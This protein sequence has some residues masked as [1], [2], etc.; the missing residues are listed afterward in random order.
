MLKKQKFQDLFSKN[1][2]KNKNSKIL[3]WQESDTLNIPPG[4]K[5]LWRGTV[6]TR[7]HIFS[8]AFYEVKA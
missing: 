6:V 2:K 3:F 7:L 4:K 5:T 8:Q 1:V